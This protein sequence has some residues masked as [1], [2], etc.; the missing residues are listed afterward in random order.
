MDSDDLAT[1]ATFLGLV[2][3]AFLVI[4][5]ASGVLGLATV[6]FRQIAGV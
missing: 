4:L 3:L 1:L 6:I 2:G 5:V